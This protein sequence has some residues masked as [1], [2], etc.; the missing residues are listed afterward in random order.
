LILSAA[1]RGLRS[2]EIDTV[3]LAVTVVSVVRATIVPGVGVWLSTVR[4]SRLVVVVVVVWLRVIVRSGSPACTIEG[5]TASFA[6]TACRYTTAKNKQEEESGDDN[7]EDDPA[8]PA[9]PCAAVAANIASIISVASSHAVRLGVCGRVVGS[10]I[11]VIA[12]EQRN[13]WRRLRL[14]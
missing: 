9:I 1:V 12:V 7:C 2:L 4:W 5:L 8:D 3:G 11:T 6:S 10:A 14:L 13:K